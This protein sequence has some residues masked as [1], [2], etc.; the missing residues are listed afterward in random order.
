MMEKF[1][2]D[3]LRVFKLLWNTEYLPNPCDR[4]F[5]PDCEVDLF[6]GIGDDV[7]CVGSAK[8]F[9]AGL[10]SGEV[11][12]R[13]LHNCELPHTTEMDLAVIRSVTVKEQFKNV[14]YLYPNY[15]VEDKPETL[16]AMVPAAM[17]VWD[18]RAMKPRNHDQ[19]ILP[20][21]LE[22]VECITKGTEEDENGHKVTVEK[23]DP[24]E[25]EEKRVA[26][27]VS[28]IEDVSHPLRDLE[29]AHVEALRESMVKEGYRPSLGCIS[30]TI[31]MDD[32][33][34]LVECPSKETIPSMYHDVTLSLPVVK[35]GIVARIVDGRHRRAAIVMCAEKD[36]LT[37]SKAPIEVILVT[38]RKGGSLTATE[39][40]KLSARTNKS[41]GIVR[42]DNGLQHVAL[43]LVRY[44]ACYREVHNCNLAEV[45]TKD[46]MDDLREADFFGNASDSSYGRY[47]R[48]VRLLCLHGNMYKLI[49]DLEKKDMNEERNPLLGVAYLDSKILS[50]VDERTALF[51]VRC[52]HDFAVENR[53][54]NLSFHSQAFYSVILR[55]IQSVQRNTDH[56]REPN[57]HVM[58]VIYRLKMI[59]G[60]RS[61]T[62]GE[63]IRNQG[64]SMKGPGSSADWEAKQFDRERR[65]IEK[66]KSSFPL[67]QDR[68]KETITESNSNEGGRKKNVTLQGTQ[69]TKDHENPPQ[70]ETIS[71][72]RKEK[73]SVRPSVRR[74][75]RSRKRRNTDGIDI[76][77][78]PPAK[79]QR[80]VISQ[81]KVTSESP[82]GR[83]KLLQI[84]AFND[85]IP[86]K[87]PIGCS[88]ES[89][90]DPFLVS[91]LWIKKLR[92][93]FQWISD[94]PHV[95]AALREPGTLDIAY[96]W[97]FLRAI[98]IP[99]GHRANLYFN[100]KFVRANITLA[101]LIGAKIAVANIEERQSSNWST[102]A[103]LADSGAFM[104]YFQARA[105]EVHEKGFTIMEN[106]ADPFRRYSR[107]ENDAKLPIEEFP[108]KTLSD[109][110]SYFHMKFEEA[111]PEELAAGN[112]VWNPIINT[113]TRSVDNANNQDGA[114]RFS[115]THRALM[116]DLEQNKDSNWVSRR[117]AS[118]D[119][120]IGSLLSLLNIDKDGMEGFRAMVPR[121]G[122][123][124][125]LTAKNCPDQCGHND[126]DHRKAMGASV[127]SGN[128][129]MKL[130]ASSPG[131]FTLTTCNYPVSLWVAPGS[132]R[133]VYE[134]DDVK[135]ILAK[136]LRMIKVNIPSYSVFVGHGHV[137]HAG[138]AW[139]ASEDSN[140]RMESFLRY[141]MYVSPLGRKIPDAIMFAF[142]TNWKTKREDRAEQYQNRSVLHIDKP[143]QKDIRDKHLDEEVLQVVNEEA[144]VRSE[145][146]RKEHGN[147]TLEGRSNEET[148]DEE[149]EGE[150]ENDL[151]IV[152]MPE[153]ED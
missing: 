111:T 40:I 78:E 98:H 130:S 92:S 47:A 43:S 104:S 150:F 146:S 132:H 8:L 18:V 135:E 68:L 74:S 99:H 87:L 76:S 124:F 45:R 21:E 66:I 67:K 89:E 27:H 82:K 90:E 15:G 106:M 2:E 57:E 42:R 129:Y 96:V 109:L 35:P 105:V 29:Y 125:L 36:C 3:N 112:D 41:A 34:S 115:S 17:Y 44:A 60:K 117:R 55:L 145:E 118:L 69:S 16:G 103:R 151:D 110:F 28:A 139:E 12:R 81:K 79:K 25:Y 95:N 19:E 121:T 62:L 23:F 128:E 123:R 1:L 13:T 63:G 147:Q 59:T 86:L 85:T 73:D 83:M 56:E 141:H 31:M 48:L 70:E 143:T 148:D 142:N 114:A 77:P 64:V 4:G 152:D 133:Y 134:S 107:N 65:F 144:A 24:R 71:G 136:S 119:V 38:R 22:G 153:I 127:K 101:K 51:M 149:S 10:E 32:N 7:S 5:I 122:G 75:S 100:S 33:S 54:K 61:V 140:S 14:S 37:W 53:K 6:L 20:I 138:T 116:D 84:H 11:F 88:K 9:S 50:T 58:D 131:F 39:V 120:W 46:I 26:I 94:V 49:G 137:Q 113:G 126:F 93:P 30:V 72:K 108:D 91:P 97:P 52:A 80:S 102:V